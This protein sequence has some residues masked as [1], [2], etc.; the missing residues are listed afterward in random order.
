MKNEGLKVL[1]GSPIEFFMP[2]ILHV[3]NLHVMSL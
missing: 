2:F 3:F 1:G